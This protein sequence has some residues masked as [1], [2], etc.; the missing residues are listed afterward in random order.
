MSFP[1]QYNQ[2]LIIQGPTA[3]GK[4]G[5]AME[6]AQHLNA[7]IMNADSLQWYED[8]PILTAQPTDSEKKLRDHHLFAELD[9]TQRGSVA[10][11]QSRA[12]S[13]IEQYAACK[14]WLFIVGGTGLYLKS[15]LEGLSPV[16]EIPNEIR[17]TARQMATQM[18]LSQFQDFVYK[19]DP[20]L[21]LQKN[22]PVDIQRLTRVLEVKLA[23]NNSLYSFQEHSIPIIKIPEHHIITICPLKED[24]HQR[25]RQRL[26]SMTENGVL[27]EIKKFLEKA[28]LADCMV[29][30]ALGFK[31]FSAYLNN[32]YTLKEALEFAFIETRQYAKRQMTWIKGQM[33]QQTL[34]NPS[35]KNVIETLN[36]NPFRDDT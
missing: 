1:I 32:E 29:K 30:R 7:G 12:I 14:K 22:P 26:I 23:T 5:F 4:S 31:A 3:S 6:L 35:V 2:I 19:V 16:P 13:V 27:C 33:P 9:Y 10:M 34:I 28:P 8:L 17:Q 18:S 36:I 11:W 20:L 21:L 15:L 24:L 25:M